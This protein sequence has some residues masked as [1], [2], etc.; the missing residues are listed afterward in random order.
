MITNTLADQVYE[1]LEKEILT[2]VYKR[3]EIITET[4]LCENLGVSRTPVR[5]ALRRLEQDHIIESSGKGMTV[6]GITPEDVRI[7]YEI[8]S[9]V[10]GLAAAACAKNATD[11][12]IEEMKE[13]VDLQ[14]FY[15][16]KKDS[17]KVKTMD[18]RFHE[19]LYQ[20]SGSTI[21]YDTLMPLHTKVQK[22]RKRSVEDNSRASA[23]TEEHRKI[24]D[25]IAA[26]D[27][28]AARTAA[29]EHVKK[30]GDHIMSMDTYEE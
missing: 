10:E 14:E 27:C 12:Q 2:G 21:Y 11:E 13:F 16:A 28:R 25:A 18:S 6:L 23:S 1:R 29:D 4:A 22:V 30:A 8:R 17:E 20:Y 7:I 19:K 24:L 3:G 15:V 26:H 9:R 5:E